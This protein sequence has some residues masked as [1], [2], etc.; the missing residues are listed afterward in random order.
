MFMD[1][2]DAAEQRINGLDKSESRKRG[3]YNENRL[4]DDDLPV[5]I[6][7]RMATELSLE[8]LPAKK[9]KTHFRERA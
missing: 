6:A 1:E 9:L 3:R 5:T 8:T 4:I 7:R 2:L